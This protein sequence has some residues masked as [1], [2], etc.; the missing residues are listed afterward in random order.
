MEIVKECAPRFRAPQDNYNTHMFVCQVFFSIAPRTFSGGAVEN[1]GQSLIE[2]AVAFALRVPPGRR[3][4]GGGGNAP[5][6]ATL[7][8]KGESE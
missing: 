7:Y 4:G 5:Q 6:L 2:W 8:L 1:F 3:P